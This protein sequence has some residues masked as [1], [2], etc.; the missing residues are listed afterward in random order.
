MKLGNVLSCA[1]K[2]TASLK[3]AVNQDVSAFRLSRCLHDIFCQNSKGQALL[4]RRTYAELIENRNCFGNQ[5]LN[6]WGPFL[7]CHT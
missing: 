3:E 1:A 4:I 2:A 7:A 5:N 6:L